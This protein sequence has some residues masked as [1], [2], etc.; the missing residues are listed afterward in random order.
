MDVD[1]LVAPISDEFPC[2]ED[3]EYEPEFGELERAAMGKAAQ[4]MGDEEI[5]AEPPD[6]ATVYNLAQELLGRSN[7]L[8]IAVYLT[9]AALNQHGPEGLADGLDLFDR[10]IDQYWDTVHPQLDPEDDYDP[11]LRLNSILPLSDPE[12]MVADLLELQLVDS[13]AA[14]KFKLRDLRVANGELSPLADQANVPDAALINAA[15][16]D[17]DIDEIQASSEQIVRA[18]G[19][20]KKVEAAILE[21]VGGAVAPNFSPLTDELTTIQALYA[22]KLSARGIG[23]EMPDVGGSDGSASPAGAG[24]SGDI[25]SREDAVRMIDK[26]CQFYER[27]EPSSPVPML[28][29]R[30][31]RLVAMDY[32]DIMRDLTPDGV[33]QAESI[34]GVQGQSEDGY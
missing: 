33:S 8:R 23:V 18:I 1:Q 20:V 13:K 21:Q 11:M 15:F 12:G 30:A 28:L 10:L 19:L 32:L 5:E 29:K 34:G 3:L 16:L 6:W 17:A 14:G 27:A 22:E 26:I 25:Q 4:V 31:K 7:D 2:G 24:I 9:R